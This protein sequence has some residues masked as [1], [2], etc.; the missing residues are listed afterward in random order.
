MD[1][2]HITPTRYLDIF[3]AGR[4]AHLVL[5][6]LVEEDEKYRDW[7]RE[8]KKRSNCTI[9]LDNSAFE[10]YK[11]GE[12]MYDSDK[13][14][15]MAEK[16]NA[17]YV[18]MS[19]YPNNPA[20]KTEKKAEE[21]APILRA[22]KRGRFFCPQSSIGHVHELIS[23]YMWAVENPNIDYIGFSILN[24]PNAYGVEKDNKLQRFLSRWRFCEE[25]TLCGFFSKAL[26][27]N[28][29][30]HLLGMLDGPNEIWLLKDFIKVF[31][32]WDSSAAVWA[33]LHGIKFDSSPTGLINGKFEKE[34]DFASDDATIEEIGIA[35]QNCKYIDNLL[36][37][38]S[39]SRV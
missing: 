27:N 35:M 4:K 25:L 19:D 9:I 29:K 8:E 1:F 12:P 39:V 31:H 38:A 32:T 10:M 34:V 37:N 33:G 24:I 18:V 2:C 7:Y 22:N 3:A 15:A 11:R 21:M 13:L 36:E 5:A 6:H 17:D 30:L 26:R 28:K 16:V 20:S 23:S 14:V